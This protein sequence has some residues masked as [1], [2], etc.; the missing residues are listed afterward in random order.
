MKVRVAL[1]TLA[2]AAGSLSGCASTADPPLSSATSHVT[3]TPLTQQA[4]SAQAKKAVSKAEE[5]AQQLA[6][7]RRHQRALARAV[8]EKA[9]E[10]AAVAAK[11][12]Q[13]REAAL[14]AQAQKAKKAAEEARARTLTQSQVHTCT[15]TSSGSCIR[16]GELCKQ[17]E[18][19]QSGYDADGTRYVCK[20]DSSHPHWE[21]P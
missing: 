3:P 21:V 4:K 11:K 8:R 1:A 14:Q 7:A 2:I 13:E 20:G 10:A 17:S 18:Y 6:K 9:R 5:A 15:Q 16:G 19:D 12:A